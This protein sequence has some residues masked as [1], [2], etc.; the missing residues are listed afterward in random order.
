MRIGR[1]D[2]PQPAVRH[3]AQHAGDDPRG[4]DRA[5]HDRVPQDAAEPDELAGAGRADGR[6]G[7][8]GA[9]REGGRSSSELGLRDPAVGDEALLD[10]M[11]AH[12]IL[13]ERPIVVSDKG[14]RLCRPAETV[15]ELLP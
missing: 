1:D 6:A 10:A 13:I 14:V 9:A 15:R 2:L 4:G 5:A 11:A 12:P 7:A 8:R 3:L